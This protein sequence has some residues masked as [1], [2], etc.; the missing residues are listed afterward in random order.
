MAEETPLKTPDMDS[1]DP[2]NP[3]FDSILNFRDVGDT[4]NKFLGK[5]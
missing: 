5:K 4:V 3:G 1:I 2:F